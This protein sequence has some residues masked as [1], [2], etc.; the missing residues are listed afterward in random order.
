MHRENFDWVRELQNV[1]ARLV[2]IVT[3]ASGP[4]SGERSHTGVT[5]AY[6]VVTTPEQVVVEIELPGVAKDD[7]SLT[8]GGEKVSLR[9]ERRENEVENGIVF[10]R[11][12]RYGSLSAQF[13]LPRDVEMDYSRAVAAFKD[14]VLTITIPRKDP[15]PGVSIPIQ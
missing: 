15:D 6:D 8:M 3:N 7:I 14:G 11:T 9:C 12:R 13:D 2:N 1:S 4:R 10:R 5:F